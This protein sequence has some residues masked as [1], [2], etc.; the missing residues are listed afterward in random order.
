MR[1]LFKWQLFVVVALVASTAIGS[2]IYPPFRHALSSRLWPY[3]QSPADEALGYVKAGN[4]EQARKLALSAFGAGTTIE[5]I[6]AALAMSSIYREGSPVDAVRYAIWMSRHL[7]PECRHGANEFHFATT[8][9]KRASNA[10]MQG[11]F[12]TASKLEQQASWL[13]RSA[14]LVAYAP[15]VE[16]CAGEAA[17]KAECNHPLG[18][19]YWIELAKEFPK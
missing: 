9:G 16:R 18:T 7:C 6:K 5:K 11:D 12:E 4:Y 17:D 8:L 10:R 19:Q 3:R 2:L 13:Y 1:R 14:V 15:A